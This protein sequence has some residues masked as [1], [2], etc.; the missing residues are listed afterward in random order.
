[1]VTH[2]ALEPD[3]LGLSLTDCDLRDPGP[4]FHHLFFGGDENGPHFVGLF[5]GFND[6]TSINA[7]NGARQVCYLFCFT[8]F[9]W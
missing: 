7:A 2:L 1:M 3:C 4:Q 6:L 9:F 8:L 5:Q